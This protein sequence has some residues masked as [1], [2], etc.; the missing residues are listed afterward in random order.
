MVAYKNND[1]KLLFA[2]QEKL[3]MSLKDRVLAMRRIVSNDGSTIPGFDK[4]I[5]NSSWL[6]FKLY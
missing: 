4:I 2:L 1:Q 3:M 6:N 5:W